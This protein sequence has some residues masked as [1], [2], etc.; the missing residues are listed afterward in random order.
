MFRYLIAAELALL[1]SDRVI[2]RLV[3]DVPA[4]FGEPTFSKNVR[5]RAEKRGSA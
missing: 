4:R 5:F 2:L 1:R 3:D